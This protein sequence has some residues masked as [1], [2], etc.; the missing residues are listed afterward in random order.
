MASE[1]RKYHVGLIL[2]NQYLDQLDR[3]IRLAVLGNVGTL[4]SFRLGPRDA[5]Y[6]AREFHPDVEETDLV[7]LPN[8]DIYLKLMID[9]A[10]SKTFSA[11]TLPPGV[12]IP[13]RQPGAKPHKATPTLH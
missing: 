6:M 3:D 1:L 5:G 8:Y 11:T 13:V 9:G 7:R 4:I 2:A 10:P 12:V